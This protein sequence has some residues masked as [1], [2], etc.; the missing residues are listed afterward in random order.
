[1]VQKTILDKKSIE[2]V[3]NFAEIF[4][5]LPADAQKVALDKINGMVLLSKSMMLK[6]TKGDENIDDTDGKGVVSCY[7]V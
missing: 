5:K 6:K 7:E 1:M 4:S 2:D 3:K